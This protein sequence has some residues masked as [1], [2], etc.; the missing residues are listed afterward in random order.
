MCEGLCAER[1]IRKSLIRKKSEGRESMSLQFVFGNS[2]S[3]KSHYL[4]EHMIHESMK[5]PDRNYIVLVPEQFTMQTQ[6]EL[7]TRHPRHGIMNID[8]LSFARLAFRVLEETGAGNRVILDDEG[9]NLI[10]R[11][12]AGKL[13]PS[14]RVLKGNVKKTGYISEV[15]SVISELTQYNI[16][17]EAM[18][19]MI[20][21]VEESSYL[22]W[23]LRDIQTLYEAF[24]EYLADKYITKEEILDV[25]C[26]VM[27]KSDILKDSVVALDG[28]TGFTPVQNKVLGEMLRHCRKVI[29]TVTMDEREDPYVLTDKYQL[30]ALSKQMVTSLVRIAGEEKVWIEAPVCLYGRP[31]YRFREN[32][33]LAHLEAELFRYS[34]KAYEGNTQSV[35]VYCSRS[36]KEEAE[37]A[38]QRIR[39]L[40]R[41]KGYRYRE[42]AVIASDMNVYADEIEKAFE[43]YEIPV[44][45]DYKRSVLLNSFVEYVRSLL[46]MVEQNFTCE[47]VFRFLRTGLAGFTEEEMDI[48]ENYVRALGIRGYKKWQE[49]WIRRAQTTTEEELEWLNHLRVRFVEKISELVFVLKQRRKTVKD[50]TTALYEFLVKEELQRQV[51]QQEL[52]FVEEGELALAKEY[53]QIYRV[54]IELFDKFVGLLGEECISMKEYRELLDAGMEEARIGVIPPSLDE[55]MVGDIERTRLKDIRVLLLLGVNDTWIPGTVSAGGLL[56]DRDRERFEEQGITLA[57]GAREKTYIQKFYLYLHMTKPTQELDVSYSKLSSEGRSIRPAY[58]IT[59]LK[60]MFPRLTVFD[61]ERYGMEAMELVPETGIDYLIC[62]LRDAEK[63]EHAA[64]QEL[65]RWY[66]R[67]GEWRPAVERLV[68]ASMYRKPQDALTVKTAEKLYGNRTASV[69]RLEKFAACACS[70]FLTYGL[71]IK[72]R[73]EYEFAAL[74]FGNIF[75]KSMENYARKLEENGE[76]WTE[77]TEEKQRQYVSESVEES[78]VDYSN[79]VLYSSARNAYVIPRMKRM[80]NRTIWAMTKQLRKGTFKPEGFEVNFGSG[81]IDRIDVCETDDKVYVKI[82]DYKTGAKAFDMAALY[83]GLQ[84]QLVVYMSEALELE[85]RKHPGKEPVPAGVFYYRMKDPVVDKNIDEEKLEDA[86]LRE[87]R[88]DGLVSS[89]EAVIQRLDAEFTGSSAVI[90]VGKTRTGYSKASRTLRPEEFDEVLSFAN[91]RREKLQ[92]EMKG[93]RADAEPYEMGQQTGCDYCPYKNICG[94]D[95]QIEGYEYRRLAKMSKD[96]VLRKMKEE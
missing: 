79:T 15:K 63:M 37:C 22:A 39:F 80:M 16:R 21:A 14:L 89:D 58:L 6:K 85:K 52:Q 46:A 36:P 2:G 43:K 83:H 57:P 61:M 92:E 87:L 75:H 5:Y 32:P 71:R 13:E 49:K 60:R 28:F 86:I 34:G 27:P 76:N 77:V 10:L 11:K 93:G 48:L 8:V 40:V 42:I 82:I 69:S 94:F 88:L 44:F 68:Q 51:K 4:Y 26:E 33:A 45:M 62:G 59:D 67:C 9:K 70:H 3:G 18:G 53:A 31:V 38:A 66:M 65:Y 1:A 73:E 84:M 23:K 41:K 35:R 55:V 12:L 95:G 74:D 17:P 47:S 54:V 78:I 81:K 20:E 50:V 24:E 30:F 91:R 29:V 7:V 96:E 90:P 19:T 25:L 56:S 72:E 64:W